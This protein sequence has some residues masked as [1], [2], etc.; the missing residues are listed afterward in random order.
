MIRI[1][2]LHKVYDRRGIAGVRGVSFS[3]EKGTVMGIMGPNGGGKST[4][5]KLLQ[6]A[7]QADEG[8]VSIE[9]KTVVFPPEEMPENGNVQ[10]LLVSAITLDVDDE[11]KIQLARDLADTFEFTFQLRQNLS[12][13]SSGQR[14]KVL[15][16]RELINRPALL[17]MDEP[18][19]HMD[20]FTRGDILRGLFQFIKQQEITVLW[21][22]HERDEALQFSD[23]LGI[24]NFGK[25]EQLDSPF[26]LMKSPRNLFV[27]QFMGLKNFFP[28]KREGDFW[29]TPWGKKS[30]ES[31]L[32]DE[33][34]LVVPD[35]S[36]KLEEDGP[37]LSLR[38]KIVV[39]QG[40]RYVLEYQNQVI[41]AEF[42]I[43]SLPQEEIR[44]LVPRF[45][46]CFL[47]PL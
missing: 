6:G 2:D 10:K 43:S 26:A 9:G 13:L 21:V 19:A 31:S 8:T 7:I 42:L 27:A 29:I 25:F 4:L 5:L 37:P 38:E 16:A 3:L 24:M 15:L 47:I 18:F 28:V 41:H 14:Q 39:S 23:K 12:E 1:S 11:K 46:E 32:K 30:F 44:F 45:E 40:M 17:L 34:L 22:T 35:R 36:W 20:P 33:A